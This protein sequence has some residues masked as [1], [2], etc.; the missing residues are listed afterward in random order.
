VFNENELENFVEGSHL[1][2]VEDKYDGIR[3]KK[4]FQIK[5]F[6]EV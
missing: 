6:K 5:R 1:L 4:K 2:G 3:L